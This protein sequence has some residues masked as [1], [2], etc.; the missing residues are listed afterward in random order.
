MNVLMNKI[1]MVL[2]STGPR[3]TLEFGI[4]A[5][6]IEEFFNVIVT[7]EDVHRGKPNP[8]MFMYAAQLLNFIPEQCIVFGNSN[9]KVEAA[10]DA[11]MKCVVV[12][13]KHPLYELRAANLVVRYL[14]E[15]FVVD[16][17][18]LA[19]IELAEFGSEEEEAEMKEEGDDPYPS[20]SV[21]ID[22]LW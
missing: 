18:N 2:V 16:L 8:E 21:A 3:K 13:S 20:T 6:G 17:K 15:L 9:S 7:V 11:C 10:H 12:A 4:G 19:N 22:D 1:L 14:D 5:I